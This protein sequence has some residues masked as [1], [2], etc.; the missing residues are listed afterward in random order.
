MVNVAGTSSHLAFVQQPTDTAA[1]APITPAVTVQLQDSF[2]NNVST[3]GVAI[4]L[5]AE[6]IAGGA[7]GFTAQPAEVTDATGLATF[8]GLTFT[9]PGQFVLLAQATAVTT[10]TSSA[11]TIRAGAPAKIQATGGTPQTA[12]IQTAFAQPLTAKVLDAFDNPV[13]GVTVTFTAPSSG[14]SASLSAPAVTDATGQTAVTATANS[15]AGLYSVT[16]ATAGVAASA[17]FSLTNATGSV[18]HVVFVQQPS[19]A[20]AGAVISPPVTVKVTDAGSNPLSGVSVTIQVQGGTPA[21][22]GT[23]SCN[24]GRQ[25]RGYVCRS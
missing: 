15:V 25:R 13:S 11:F 3:P 9:Q 4:T 1:G 19:N 17:S 16:A 22:G 5:Q 20:A 14:A 23:L 2:G 18:G 10:A 8:A 12:T 24:H 7:S 6:H 21:L